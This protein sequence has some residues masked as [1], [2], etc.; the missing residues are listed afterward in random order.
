MIGLR[1]PMCNAVIKLSMHYRVTHGNSLNIL[2]VPILCMG[3]HRYI[4]D[5]NP[6]Y[7]RGALKVRIPTESAGTRETVQ[8]NLCRENRRSGFARQG[9]VCQFVVLIAAVKTAESVQCRVHGDA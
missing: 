9:G 8:M 1:V 2:L 4:I 7:I 5:P 6:I 3:M